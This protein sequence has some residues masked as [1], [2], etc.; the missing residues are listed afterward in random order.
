MGCRRR[1]FR[2]KIGADIATLTAKNVDLNSFCK[3]VLWT[4]V[5]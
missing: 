3:L 1:K 4:L 5:T 2:A